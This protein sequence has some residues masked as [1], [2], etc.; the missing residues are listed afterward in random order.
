MNAWKKRRLAVISPL[1]ALCSRRLSVLLLPFVLFVVAQHVSAAEDAEG[2]PS[3]PFEPFAFELDEADVVDIPPP[4]NHQHAL[5]GTSTPRTLEPPP[6]FTASVTTAFDAEFAKM[7]K[8]AKKKHGE[9]TSRESASQE[10]QTENQTRAEEPPEAKN[11]V[12]SAAEITFP[13]L[14]TKTTA[15][16]P[17]ACESEG[18]SATFVRFGRVSHRAA[19]KLHRRMDS[20]EECARSCRDRMTPPDGTP[21]DCRGFAFG[22]RAA[23][24]SCEFFDAHIFDITPPNNKTTTD[25]PPISNYFERA[26]LSIPRACANGAYAFDARPDRVLEGV[27]RALEEQAVAS[28]KECLDLCLRNPVCRAVHHHRLNGT[29]ELLERDG[30]TVGSVLTEASGSDF[31]ENRNFD[32]RTAVGIDFMLTRNTSIASGGTLDVSLGPLSVRNCMRECVESSLINCRAVQHDPSSRECVLLETSGDLAVAQQAA[33]AATQDLYEP[34]CLNAAIDL[35]CP[36]DAAF[37]RVPRTN[38]LTEDV[39]AHLKDVTLAV[40]VEACLFDVGCRAFTYHRGEQRCKILPLNRRNQQ[41]RAVV[42]TAVDLFELACDRDGVLRDLAPSTA[43]SSSSLFPPLFATKKPSTATTHTPPPTTS[44]T[45]SHACDLGQS[46]VV[47]KGRTLRLDYRNL[48]HVNVHEA[49][50]CERLCA[51]ASI[52]CATFA[53]NRRTGDCLLSTA[54]VEKSGGLALFTQPNPSYELFAFLGAACAFEETTSTTATV[55]STAALPV[56]NDNEASADPFGGDQG[57]ANA[58]TTITTSPPTTLAPTAAIPPI[59]TEFDGAVRQTTAHV[60]ET[61]RPPLLPR[62]NRTMER[63]ET[64]RV[65]VS[66]VC[67]E[68]G[69]NVTFSIDQGNYTGAVYAAERFSQCREFVEQQSRFSLFVTRPSVDNLCNALEE[70]GELTAV[71]VL[72]NDAVHPGPEPKSLMSSA[73][74]AEDKQN[75]VFLKI[76]KNGKPVTNVFIGE[77]LTAVV[78]SDVDSNRLRITECNATRVGGL[79][80]RP[81][82]VQLIQEGCS[83]MPQVM[84]NLQRVSH[85][86]EAPFTAFRIDGSDQID[87]VCGIVDVQCP[88]SRNKRQADEPTDMITVDQRLRVLVEDPRIQTTETPRQSQ[89]LMNMMFGADIAATDFCL[90]PTVFLVL[91][92]VLLLCLVLLVVSLTLHFCRRVSRFPRY[93]PHSAELHGQPYHIPRIERYA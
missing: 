12:V 10:F 82:S 90:N 55:Q 29:C 80:P 76:L 68:K 71:L 51:E 66:A 65:R 50:K 3:E 5:I 91:V 1:A 11:R 70:D 40:C 87:I 9:S 89:S 32:A 69:V 52:K 16:P 81:H 47:E 17:P 31:Y 6:T 30:A 33:S 46:V 67:L 15:A 74:K 7:E 60:V 86:F 54:A 39:I 48:H 49:E 64:S 59:R 85:G 27:G 4:A 13:T 83:L 88:Q 35:P 42:E 57:K 37:E 25:G 92:S 84:G 43:A 36:G 18:D 72:S 75:R 8:E 14:R 62:R 53:F 26:C 77:K 78:E 56:A 79:E 20:L 28:R 73:K 23:G 45:T 2:D 93:S 58:T 38:L 19:A 22:G 61:R 34:I 24:N 21:F 44:A 41:T 63:L